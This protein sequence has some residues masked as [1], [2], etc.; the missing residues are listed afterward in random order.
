MQI[1]L[2]SKNEDYY[3]YIDDEDY[4]KFKKYN[5]YIKHDKSDL[6]YVYTN[7]TIDNKKTSLK[8]HRYLMGLEKGDIKIINHKDRNG[9]NNKKSNLEI[10]TTLYNSQSIN[11]KTPFGHISIVNRPRKYCAQVIIN[12]KMYCKCFFTLEEAEAYLDGLK[13]IAINETLPFNN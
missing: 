8:L 1:K 7:A 9:L 3:V 5:W 13:I 11:K 10:C 12:R 4:N 6:K 2:R